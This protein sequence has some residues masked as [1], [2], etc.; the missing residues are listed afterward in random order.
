NAIDLTNGLPSE[1]HIIRAE[2]VGQGQQYRLCPQGRKPVDAFVDANAGLLVLCGQNE[3]VHC[4]SSTF[5]R[6]VPIWEGHTREPL[7]EL[8]TAVTRDSGNAIAIGSA[9]CELLQRG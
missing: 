6:R 3:T 1:V 7:G 4:V 2:N 9:V 8:V 5:A